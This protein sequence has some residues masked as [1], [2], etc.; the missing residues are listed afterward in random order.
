M[1]IG[2]KD[3]LYTRIYINI[4]QTKLQIDNSIYSVMDDT[5]TSCFYI[6]AN[7]V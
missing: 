7:R 6:I 5:T 3:I 1:Q 2:I 4:M